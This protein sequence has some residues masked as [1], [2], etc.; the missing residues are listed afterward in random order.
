MADDPATD[1]ARA[2]CAG[3]IV[4]GPHVRDACARHLRDLEREDLYFDT[5]AAEYVFDFYR[6]VLR[7]NGGEFEALPFELLAW[8]KFVI[9]SIF[10]WKRADTGYR[11]FRLVYIETGKGLGK[12]P[13]LA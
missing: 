11:R 7:L 5:D 10:G 13:L 8:Q 9:G 4:A 6:H 2:V 3:E 1:Y 12:S